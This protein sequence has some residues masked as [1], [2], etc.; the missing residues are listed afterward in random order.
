MIGN[1]KEDVTWSL[2]VDT[3]KTTV[4]GAM[5]CG[6]KGKLLLAVSSEEKV[7]YKTMK[8]RFYTPEEQA[9]GKTRG[10]W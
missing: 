10:M 9:G 7:G 4:P 1:R 8:G 6:V 3:L 5:I 2:V